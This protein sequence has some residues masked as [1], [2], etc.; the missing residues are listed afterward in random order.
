MRKS[1]MLIAD[2][3]CAVEMRDNP[4]LRDIP[5]YCRGGSRERRRYRYRQLSC[6]PVWRTQ[7][8]ADHGAGCAPSAPAGRF[9]AYKEA[10]RHVRDIFSRYA[11]LIE[12]LAELK[13]GWM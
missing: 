1:Y 11:S 9:D 2:I 10:S 7:R 6:A 5:T 3:F 4:A 12:P 13:H 8:D